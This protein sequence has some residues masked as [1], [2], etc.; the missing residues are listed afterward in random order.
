M[1][2]RLAFALT[3][4]LA[5]VSPAAAH[6]FLHHAVP[7]VGSTIATAPS[8]VRMVFTQEIDLSFSGAT[9]STADGT[10]IATGSAALDPQ[11]PTALVLRLPP[12]A[13]GKYKVTWHVVSVDTHRT[14][15]NFT[16][17]IRP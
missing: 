15:G 1:T 8:E 17:E 7:A 5:G 4:L 14:E 3:T 12:L 16:F 11:D 6:A 2:M 9:L 13:P 10:P